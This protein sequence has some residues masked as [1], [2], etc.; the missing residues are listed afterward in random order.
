MAR[1]TAAP[2]LHETSVLIRL[3]PVDFGVWLVLAG[4]AKTLV[5]K[6]VAHLREGPAKTTPLLGDLN[7]GI[8]VEV[9]DESSG[10]L[11]VKVPDGRTGYIWG[12]HTAEPGA[13]DV[14][15][16]PPPPEAKE[17]TKEQ[18]DQPEAKSGAADDI[19][20]LRSEIATLR[21]R[22]EPVRASDIDALRSEVA[23]LVESQRE[24]ARRLNTP[25]EA[26]TIEPP[27]SA[28]A[29][30]WLGVG[31]GLIVGWFAALI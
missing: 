12:E 10:W 7:P 3:P 29:V 20:Q 25:G 18:K 14:S 11:Q 28:A 5:L 27:A 26:P 15:R 9:L 4:E 17:P 1:S 2:F 30:G 16:P 21:G 6:E 24:L 23:R 8:T 22:P 19:A 13:A 31:I